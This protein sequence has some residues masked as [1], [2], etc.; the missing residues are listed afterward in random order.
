MRFTYPS[1]TLLD[2]N[3]GCDDER[4]SNSPNPPI[5]ATNIGNGILRLN[6]GPHAGARV[7]QNTEDGAEIF[8]V[9]HVSGTSGNE[10]LLVTAF[11]ARE[12]HAGI[13]KI[14]ADGGQEFDIIEL[15]D[16]VLTP[17][18]LSG[19]NG[20]DLVIGGGAN[21]S[22]Y[23][24][25]GFDELDGGKG[26][27]QLFGGN[28]DDKLIGS[29]G[30]DTLDGGEGEDVA[31]YFTATEGVKVNIAD[32]SQN[33]GDAAGDVYISIELIEVSPHD[34]TLIGN[35]DDNLL[36]GLEGNDVLEGAEGNDILDGVQGNDI[37]RGGSGDDTIAGGEG[38][39]AHQG[40]TGFDLATYADSSGGIVLD[41]EDPSQSTG[42]AEGD[43]FDS[44]EKYEAT[45]SNDTL[46]GDGQNNYFSALGGNDELYG[47][48]GND[49]LEGN[50][51]ND[52][53]FGGDGADLL[54]GGEDYDIVS[55]EDSP[56]G[57]EVDLISP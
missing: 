3:H 10:T 36:S 52:T 40:G 42:Y 16:S 45:Y 53:L 1:L 41:L 15:N 47:N 11:G 34:D 44:I 17:A 50:E 14:I 4:D 26:D 27:D 18:E 55:Y 7:N 43:T 49:T 8:T 57:V 24:N 23:G 9:Q 51:G 46:K 21:D 29:A 32:P 13:S 25:N 31:S 20:E 5:L 28:E 22:L 38:S 56:I 30:A 6:M 54:D 2:F 48:G 19:G 33:T 39:D 35:S 12:E 37:L